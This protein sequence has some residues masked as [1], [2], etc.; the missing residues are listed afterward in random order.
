MPRGYGQCIL[1]STSILYIH[2]SET[3]RVVLAFFYPM[4]HLFLYFRNKIENLT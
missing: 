2:L 1:D 3:I 4:S